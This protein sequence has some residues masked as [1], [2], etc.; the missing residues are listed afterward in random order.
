MKILDFGLARAYTG[1]PEDRSDPA[2][3][4]TITA[5]MTQAGT[6]LGTAAYMS[7]EQARGRAVDK[8]TDIWAFGVILYEMLTG[9]RL[10][11][12]AALEGPG[13]GRG[14]DR[15]L[16]QPRVVGAAARHR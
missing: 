1:D 10:Y 16:S 2:L 14:S 7:P 12:G 8:R 13:A 6:I 9:V 3:S 4:P 11:S 5:A 15:A